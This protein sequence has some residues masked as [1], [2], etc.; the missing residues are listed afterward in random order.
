MKTFLICVI[1]SASLVLTSCATIFP[2]HNP[3]IS[4]DEFAG[5][6]AAESDLTACYERGFRGFTLL[7]DFVLG[8]P[9]LFIPLIWD[10]VSGKYTVYYYHHKRCEKM[11]MEKRNAKTSP[12]TVINVHSEPDPAFVTQKAYPNTPVSSE[13]KTE[14]KSTPQAMP[15][16]DNKP[17]TIQETSYPETED[18]DEY[19][20]LY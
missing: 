17:A 7:L 3:N 13:H 18:N 9:F 6:V 5:L 8:A 4:R 2:V 1:L 20:V 11:K 12:T 10:G 14:F 16:S 15:I 19:E